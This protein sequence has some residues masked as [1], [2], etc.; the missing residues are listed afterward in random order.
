MST[1]GRIFIVVNL[2]LT[3]VLVGFVGAFQYSAVGYRKPYEALKKS[4]NTQITAATQRAQGAVN[5]NAALKAEVERLRDSY[6]QL[7]ARL[8]T[9]YRTLVGEKTAQ[10]SIE[11]SWTAVK[12]RLDGWQEIYT[13]LQTKIGEYNTLNEELRSK[14]TELAEATRVARNREVTAASFRVRA[15]NQVKALLSQNG[16]LQNRIQE[17]EQTLSVYVALFGPIGDERVPPGL[18]GTVQRVEGE[19]ISVELDMGALPTEPK[20]GWTFALSSDRELKGFVRIWRVDGTGLVMCRIL[21]RRE[22]SSAPAPGDKIMSY[23]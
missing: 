15:D 4:G 9:V 10:K 11:E 13:D 12:G 18:V 6:G 1:V 14:Q 17:L 20:I 2:V 23:N 8:G 22:G 3:F 21:R 19:I 5:E 16:E 7:A